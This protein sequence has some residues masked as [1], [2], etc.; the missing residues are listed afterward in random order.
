MAYKFENLSYSGHYKRTVEFRQHAGTLDPVAVNNWVKVCVGI[1]SFVS[2]NSKSF[3]TE[4]LFDHIQREEVKTQID[5]LRLLS[6]IGLDGL[7]SPAEYYRRRGP[8]EKAQ[9][10]PIIFEESY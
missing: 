8:A 9:G 2:F 4:F 10:E 5:V 7:D 1:V 3:L 6:L